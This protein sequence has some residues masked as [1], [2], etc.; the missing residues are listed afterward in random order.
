MK[1][2]ILP[3]VLLIGAI[4]ASPVQAQFSRRGASF[5][6]LGSVSVE[7]SPKEARPG[8]TVQVK[9]TV[10]PSKGA[11]TYPVH[12]KDKGQLAVN[13]INWK[14]TKPSD[15]IFVGGITDPP[16]AKTKPRREESQRGD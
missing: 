12:P 1:R 5:A 16:N 14:T 3:L 13:A 8:E 15:L 10:A 6:D 7:V 9:F 11:W 2:L 4:A